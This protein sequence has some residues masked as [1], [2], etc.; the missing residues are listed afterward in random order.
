MATV[1]H[2]ALHLKTVQKAT[3]IHAAHL[4]TLIFNSAL[5]TGHKAAQQ[6][7]GLQKSKH[8][9]DHAVHKTDCSDLCL[10]LHREFSDQAALS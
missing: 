5:F 4:P 6:L 3:L 1:L 8:N 7:C 9:T 10:K 2:H